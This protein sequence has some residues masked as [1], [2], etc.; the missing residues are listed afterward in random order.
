MKKT[1]WLDVRRCMNCGSRHSKNRYI[2]RIEGTLCESEDVCANCG[3]PVYCFA[4]G[5]S[6]DYTFSFRELLSNLK[7]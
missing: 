6:E 4:Y 3:K 7:L 1:S 5:Y 2:D